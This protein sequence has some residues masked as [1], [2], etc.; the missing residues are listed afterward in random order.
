MTPDGLLMFRTGEMRE[1]NQSQFNGK[2]D[3][4]HVTV[5]LERDNAHY[6]SAP[7][8]KGTH[9]DSWAFGRDGNAEEGDKESGSQNL[10]PW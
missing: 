1:Q 2:G 7:G 9:S 3:Y 4:P 6:S 5:D 10:F 8:A